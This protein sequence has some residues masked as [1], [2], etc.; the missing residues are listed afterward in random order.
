M[1]FNKTPA[2]ARALWCEAL[3]SGKYSQTQK[4]LCN[5]NG[6]CCLGVAC[7]IFIEHE[8]GLEKQIDPKDDLGTVEYS[9]CRFLLPENVRQWLGIDSQNG[10]FSN[11]ISVEVKGYSPAHA[12]V[13]LNDGGLNF[14]QISTFI[15]SNPPGLFVE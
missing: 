1:S 3:E 4:H 15:R 2:E 8:T 13:G 9:T 14:H 5:K 6:Y 10:T 11:P 7:E 12:L